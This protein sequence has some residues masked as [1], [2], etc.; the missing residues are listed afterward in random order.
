MP[1]ASSQSRPQEIY[2]SIRKAF[3]NADVPGKLCHRCIRSRKDEIDE[4]FSSSNRTDVN[5]HQIGSHCKA[6]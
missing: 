6:Q 1:A 2:S 4:L 3:P 5:V